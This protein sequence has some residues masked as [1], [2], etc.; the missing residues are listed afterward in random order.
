VVLGQV[1][2]IPAVEKAIGVVQQSRNEQLGMLVLD[3]IMDVM[4]GTDRDELRFKLNIAMGRYGE[5]ARDA[6][7]VARFE[8]VRT[9][10]RV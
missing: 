7:E 2:K 5:A 3:Y 4:E 10:G 8:Q 6:L 9:A 1:N